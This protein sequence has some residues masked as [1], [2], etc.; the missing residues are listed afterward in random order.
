ME[1]LPYTADDDLF[2]ATREDH[3][4]RF[5]VYRPGETMVVLGKASKPGTEL[6]VAACEQDHVPMMRRR[7]GGCAVLLDPGN[8]IVCVAQ[9]APGIGE[10]KA[11]FSRLNDWLIDG[12]AVAGITGLRQDGI[13]DLV[14][15]DRKVAGACLHR[16]RDTLF[17]SASLLVDPQL[18]RMVRYLAH[19]P[20]EPPYRCGRSHA[21]FITT[22]D[23]FLRPHGTGTLAR[24]LKENLWQPDPPQSGL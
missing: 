20:H 11:H 24:R 9:H 12:L 2:R 21:E 17:Y 13:S 5:R 1:V 3:L 15:G 10:N 18:D 14:I 16:S 7:G 23:P 6:H 8:V 19:P 22:L 4:T